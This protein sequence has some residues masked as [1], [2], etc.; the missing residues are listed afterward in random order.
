[1]GTADFIY[2]SENKKE[3]RI[4]LK[5]PSKNCTKCRGI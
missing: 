4:N 1:M 3:N 2:E 5:E